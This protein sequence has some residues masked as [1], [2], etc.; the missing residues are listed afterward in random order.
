MSS[1]LCFS[2][3]WRR[4]SHD[5]GVLNFLSSGEPITIFSVAERE[6]GRAPP[7]PK[8]FLELFPRH[9]QMQQILW[10]MSKVTDVNAVAGKSTI[11]SGGLNF[12]T[13]VFIHCTRPLLFVFYFLM[14]VRKSQLVA[15]T[16][17][18]V[19]M[20][21]CPPVSPADV[22]QLTQ[23]GKWDRSDRFNSL[24]CCL[25]HWHP[26]EQQQKTQQKKNLQT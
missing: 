2:F 10:E 4:Q 3:L 11:W 7:D 9:K 1:Q 25:L 21:V 13:H 12:D 8:R 17:K 6:C 26:A 20:C 23:A 15:A 22:T 14:N 5:E 18:L 16:R 19:H 24:R